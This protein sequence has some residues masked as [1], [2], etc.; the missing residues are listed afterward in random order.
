MFQKLK[1][2]W[3]L[4]RADHALITILGIYAS[5]YYLTKQLAL[6]WEL[7]VVPVLFQLAIF[8]WNDILDY[9]TDKANNRLDRPLVRGDI[10]LFEAKFLGIALGLIAFIL[11][12]WLLPLKLALFVIGISALSFLYNWKLKDMP[13]VGNL[14]VAFTMIAPFLYVMIYLNKYDTFLLMFSYGVL[15]FG[16]SREIIKSIEDMEGDKKERKANTLPILM[17]LKGAKEIA[18][19]FWV[20]YLLILGY[21]ILIAKSFIQ[22][23]LLLIFLGAGIYILWKIHKLKETK[24]ASLLKKYML[25]LMFL[26]LLV[27]IF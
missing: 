24:E 7:V 19:I 1:S 16:L 17:G 18:L 6:P 21:L 25:W 4:S 5:Y 11:A 20:F 27:L 10:S 3:Q 9:N 12:L 14:V 13:F 8:I 23:V 26:G 2:I 15:F 22:Q